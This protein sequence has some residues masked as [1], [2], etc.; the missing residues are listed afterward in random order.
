MASRVRLLN[1]PPLL[2]PERAIRLA[3]DAQ[4]FFDSPS[5][6]GHELGRQ[7][8][9]TAMDAAHVAI[10]TAIDT[11]DPHVL[12]AALPL[13]TKRAV[14]W[15]DE[16][17]EYEIASAAAPIFPAVTKITNL[18]RECARSRSSWVRIETAKGLGPR[19]LR[20]LRG[21]SP[22]EEAEV[23]AEAAGIL[24]ELTKD[25]DANVRVAAREALGGA[26]P[27]AWAAF[28]P[29]DPL[30]KIPAA[31][32]ARLRAPLDRAAEALE[33]GVREDATAFAEAI[34]ELPDELATPLLDA[35][36]KTSAIHAKN[37][38][39]L[40]DRW[41][42]LDPNGQR[43]LDWLR[44]IEGER[45]D[46]DAGVR[47]GAVLRRRS[48]EQARTIGLRIAAHLTKD[49]D[50]YPSYAAQQLLE[51]SWPNDSDPT[52]LLEIAFGGKLEELSALPRDGGS[53]AKDTIV[54]V[55]LASKAAFEVVLEPVV[56]AFLTGFPGR[57]EGLKYTLS[58]RLLDFFHP[59]LRAHAE[60]Q[61]R[62]GDSSALSWALRYLTRGGHD[63]R[64]DPPV[65]AFL[66]EATKDPRLRA[67]IS[68][69][70]HLRPMAEAALRAQLVS[71]ELPP[72][73]VIAVASGIVASGERDL[74]SEEWA[75]V[76][77]AREAIDDP[78]RR[79]SA[80]Q[81]LPPV[82]F[83]TSEDW[84]FVEELVDGHGHDNRVAAYLGS[85]LMVLAMRGEA[86]ALVPLLERLKTRV[87]PRAL[88]LVTMILEAVRRGEPF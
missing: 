81:A 32:A 83:W 42:S 11:G 13:A 48:P 65:E 59:R 46:L 53:T 75:A 38:D 88:P 14:G 15:D 37:S 5:D 4:A 62:E 19:A 80:I 8:V 7:A 41:L 35:W 52:P 69:D 68:R 78:G 17:F 43:T 33:K 86:T 70:V 44:S 12:A 50:S 18:V 57:W 85:G 29:R 26:A 82:E 2:D 10:E 61:L 24:F 30:A 34:E 3:K 71:G 76:R 47:V 87:P 64:V 79:A 36:M 74:T 45:V 31:E 6:G 28:F 66:A 39:G 25:Q 58:E 55:A 54:R 40:I 63:R 16:H 9:K 20:S 77:L 51:A 67:V 56:D 27:P 84:A 23:D 49:R 21:E 72:E 22:E 60:V 1:E 73:E